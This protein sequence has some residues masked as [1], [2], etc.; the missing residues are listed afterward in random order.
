[1]DTN[2]MQTSEHFQ[3]GRMMDDEESS[4]RSLHACKTWCTHTGGVGINKLIYSKWLQQKNILQ[5]AASQC[6]RLVKAMY[7][8]QLSVTSLQQWRVLR[9]GQQGIEWCLKMGNI[10]KHGYQLSNNNHSVSKK[11]KKKS[12]WILRHYQT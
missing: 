10:G 6:R 4:S 9:F 8:H 5:K 12:V 1:M 7:L 11:R 3:D 2:Q